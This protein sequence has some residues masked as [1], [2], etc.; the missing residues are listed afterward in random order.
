[1]ADM[2]YN[3]SVSLTIRHGRPQEFFQGGKTQFIFRGGG[4][5]TQFFRVFCAK[6][7][8]QNR[9]WRTFSF[10]RGG[11]PLAPLQT[12]M[13]LEVGG[14]GGPTEEVGLTY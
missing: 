5:K 7:R 11:V 4:D 3:R 2:C 6:N 1:V 10:S 12:P 9:K 13:Q 14:G 8:L